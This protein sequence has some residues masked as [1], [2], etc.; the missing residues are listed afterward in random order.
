MFRKLCPETVGAMVAMFVLFSLLAMVAAVGF[1]IAHT[2]NQLRKKMQVKEPLHIL[3][4]A[5]VTGRSL[6]SFDDDD[7]EILALSPASS[8]V[9]ILPDLASSSAGVFPGS[10]TEPELQ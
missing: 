4:T 3:L 6:P 5:P 10:E 2:V 7:W 1:A 9:G 8:T